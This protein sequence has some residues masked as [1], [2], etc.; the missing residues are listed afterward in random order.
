MSVAVPLAAGLAGAG[1]IVTTPVSGLKLIPLVISVPLFH[2]LTVEPASIFLVSTVNS[3]AEPSG[4][5]V[6]LRFLDNKFTLSYML[7][8]PVGLA[9]MVVVGIYASSSTFLTV[10]PS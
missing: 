3:V 10:L 1:E 6:F 2:T 5:K 4:I 7:P 8:P 9:P